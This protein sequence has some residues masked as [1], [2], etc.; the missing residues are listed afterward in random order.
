M[1]T[2]GDLK[3]AARRVAERAV[4]D[5]EREV[6]AEVDLKTHAIKNK[7]HLVD[8]YWQDCWKAELRAGA[9]MSFLEGIEE[10]EREVLSGRHK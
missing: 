8:G 1:I 10:V 6:Q 9:A 2:F 3:E 4:A 5:Y 7:E